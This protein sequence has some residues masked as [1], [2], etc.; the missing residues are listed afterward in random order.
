[1]W[2]TEG[3]E[4]V[5][6]NCSRREGD[7]REREKEL[8]R[9]K[10]QE[11]RLTEK[12]ARLNDQQ[13]RLATLKEKNLLLVLFLLRL[14]M[15]CCSHSERFRLIV[16]ASLLVSVV[17]FLSQRTLVVQLLVDRNTD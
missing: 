8:R 16:L 2:E 1:V 11:R 10:G 15:R 17:T 6:N 13:K 9:V 12:K 5:P 14:L 3:K 4:K 7:Q